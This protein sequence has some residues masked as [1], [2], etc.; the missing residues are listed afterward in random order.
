M[1]SRENST[2]LLHRPPTVVVQ[3]HKILDAELIGD[4]DP[5]NA[6]SLTTNPR[7]IVVNYKCKKSGISKVDINLF[8]G[9]SGLQYIPITFSVMKNCRDPTHWNIRL[10]KDLGL[11]LAIIVILLLSF[12]YL[13]SYGRRCCNIPRK[14]HVLDKDV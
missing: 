8:I 4:F 13:K 11:C 1:Y 3:N 12:P 9:P 5:K 10:L 2:L 6:V 7:E 14:K